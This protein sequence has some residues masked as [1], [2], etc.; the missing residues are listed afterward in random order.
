[1]IG[2][3][4]VDGKLP[5]QGSAGA[6]GL[7]IHATTGT[8]RVFA[9]QQKLIKTGVYLTR[10]PEDVYLRVSPRS[11]LANKHGIN[12]LAGVI[13]SDYRGEICVILQN[14]GRLDV[15]FKQGDAIAQLIPTQLANVPVFETFDDGTVTERGAEGINSTD[16]RLQGA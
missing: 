1:M 3:K 15:T 13:D 5:V 16:M 4:L 6:A 7:D 10:C 9:G 2:F 14:T 12:V 8:W 11:K